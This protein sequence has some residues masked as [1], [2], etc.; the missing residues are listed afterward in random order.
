M[1]ETA[2]EHVPTL[3]SVVHAPFIR[4]DGTMA[5][6][7]GFD[8]ASSKYLALPSSWT[9]P[10]IPIQP[11]AA[12]LHAA[13]NLIAD[14]LLVDFPFV[15][16]ADK[17]HAYSMLLTPV[18]RACIDGPTPLHLVEA[19]RQGTGKSLLVDTVATITA[20]KLPGT[21]AYTQDESEMQ[22]T[23]TAEL[24]EG[25]SLIIL[26]NLTGRI[27]SA[28]LASALTETV[29]RGRLL[30]KS[31][32]LYL[33]LTGV[34]WLATGNN[35]TLGADFPR[36]VVRIR[37]NAH[38]DQ[39]QQRTGWRHELPTWARE[40]RAELLAALF[41]LVRAWQ[42]A[43][44]PPGHQIRGRYEGWSHVIGGV[45]EVAGIPGFL[46]PDAEMVDRDTEQWRTL[47]Q[48]WWSR[49]QSTPVTSAQVVQIALQGG[50]IDRLSSA[51][52]ER[53]QTTM[54][55]RLLQMRRDQTLGT[56]TICVGA[57]DPRRNT[58]IYS[59]SVAGT[60]AEGT[61]PETRDEVP[62]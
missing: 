42:A 19:P 47:V 61:G 43:G 37:L 62:F 17:A 22:K 18:L 15:S 52:T 10:P 48:V 7:P 35:C 16:A 14:E 4:R 24:L 58:Q 8:A 32:M 21:K 23:L 54:M 55:G 45:L 20:G 49:Y 26:D 9:M 6:E 27:E 31:R 25:P 51:T 2:A 40:H 12:E 50:L 3:T 11:S 46:S 33:P 5:T 38:V 56:Y 30:G 39:P 34:T 44:S 28:A 60:V 29:H 57:H 53:A 41:T 59:L 36:R 13:V 1:R